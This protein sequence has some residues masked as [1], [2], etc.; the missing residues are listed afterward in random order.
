M[1]RLYIH[2]HYR[3]A[4]HTISMKHKNPTNVILPVP[5]D[6]FTWDTPEKRLER[7]D[8]S[9]TELKDIRKSLTI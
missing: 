9:I 6:K 2:I 1:G 8:R 7:L 5:K 3:P 4:K